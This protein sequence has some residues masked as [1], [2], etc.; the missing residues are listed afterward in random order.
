MVHVWVSFFSSHPPRA[1]SRVQRTLLHF[2]PQQGNL[3]SFG[4]CRGIQIRRA[5]SGLFCL[6]TGK[7][8]TVLYRVYLNAATLLTRGGGLCRGSCDDTVG[9]R[10]FWQLSYTCSTF[11]KSINSS[12]SYV[13][14]TTSGNFFPTLTLYCHLLSCR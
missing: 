14:I 9:C 10:M 8:T 5:M 3:L 12:Q 13:Q 4:R 2:E 11:A 6:C 1:D 7:K